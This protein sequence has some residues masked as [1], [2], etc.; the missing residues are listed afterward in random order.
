MTDEK[1]TFFWSGPFSNWYQ[2]VTFTVDGV[3]YNCSEQYMMAEKARMF[4]D[5]ETL[6]QIMAAGH[7]RDQKRLGRD[8]K[9]FDKSKWN[10][11]ARDIVFKG[12]YA[13][14]TQNDHLK[15]KLL[16]TVGTTLVE[17]SPKDEIWGIGLREDDP[18]AQ[19]RDTWC[20][21]NWLGECLTKVRDHILS[22]KSS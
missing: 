20:G 7:P 17:A 18:R 9:D 14:F 21:S 6:S 4:N 2:P 10:S 16:A 3:I 15:T 1:F 12:C 13:K 5:P 19:H 11:V 22:E 8:V